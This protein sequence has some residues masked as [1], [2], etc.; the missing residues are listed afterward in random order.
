MQIQNTLC[1]VKKN[2]KTNIKEWTTD[3]ILLKWK[4]YLLT[5]TEYHS[6]GIYVILHHVKILSFEK[7]KILKRVQV[8]SEFPLWLSG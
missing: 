5:N 8:T 3:D 1:P 2:G 6:L 7:K 4:D